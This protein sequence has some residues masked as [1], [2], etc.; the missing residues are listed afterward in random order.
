MQIKLEYQE[1]KGKVFLP[2][3]AEFV[4]Y[5]QSC[6]PN[7]RSTPAD[8]LQ[9]LLR[10]L[11]RIG[12]KVTLWIPVCVTKLPLLARPPFPACFM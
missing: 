11:N 2:P 12:L 4:S 9:P 10:A 1:L 3:L 7:S 6:A 5:F 8:L